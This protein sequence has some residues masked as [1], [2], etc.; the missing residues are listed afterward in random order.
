MD[1][2]Q[3]S[4]TNEAELLS[5]LFESTG[6]T[7]DEVATSVNH[8]GCFR[9][10]A[11]VARRRFMVFCCVWGCRTIFHTMCGALITGIERRL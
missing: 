3:N 8:M 1:W 4:D 7:G 2:V 5:D 9:W 6:V 10:R 11:I